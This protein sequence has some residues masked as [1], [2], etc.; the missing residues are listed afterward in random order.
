MAKE[1]REGQYDWSAEGQEKSYMKRDP[2]RK[3][4]Q[5]LGDVIIQYWEFGFHSKCNSTLGRT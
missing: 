1:Q 4:D 5:L 2:R 3:Q